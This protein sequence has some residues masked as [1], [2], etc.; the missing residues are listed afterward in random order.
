MSIA[1]PPLYPTAQ[2]AWQLVEIA[3]AAQDLEEFAEGVLPAV[4]RTMRSSSVFLYIADPRLPA[5]HSLQHGLPPDAVSKTESLC[6]ELFDQV[7]SLPPL[8]PFMISPS[9]GWEAAAHVVLYPLRAKEGCGG[10]MGLAADEVATATSAAALE[11]LFCLLA[12]A[13]SRLVERAQL[14]RQLARLN[15]YLTVSSMLAQELGLHELLEMV[16]Y[17]CVEA[18]SA[19]TASVL[20]LDDDK[21]SFRFYQVEGPTKPILEAATFPAGEGLTGS[22][23][24]TQQSEIINDVRNDPRFYREVDAESGFQT[25]NMIAVPLT[26]GEEQVGVLEVL[27]KMNGGS[28]TEEERLLL[29]SISEEIAFAI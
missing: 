18:V 27:N 1:E 11:R 3:L 2:E 13:I 6:A 12:S 20:L 16:L 22:V 15:T 4:A 7:S 23:L 21:R 14:E 5:P 25:R 8:R 24:Q 26:A 9:P 19:E 28:F 17:C 10:L 29:L